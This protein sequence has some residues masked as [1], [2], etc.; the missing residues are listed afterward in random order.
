[1]NKYDDECM[2]CLYRAEGK[3]SGPD[4]HCNRGNDYRGGKVNCFFR[5][6][7]IIAPNSGSNKGGSR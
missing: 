1:M 6:D 3:C 7:D 5:A 4:V 2:V